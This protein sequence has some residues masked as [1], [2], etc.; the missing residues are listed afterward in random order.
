MYSVGRNGN[1]FY[2]V[3]IDDCIYQAIIIKRDIEK[4]LFSDNIPGEEY[5]FENR[6]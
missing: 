2:S 4:N 3:D 1:Y 5:G 6:I